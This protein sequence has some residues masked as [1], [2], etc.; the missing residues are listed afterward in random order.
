M[1]LLVDTPTEPAAPVEAPPVHWLRRLWPLP[2]ALAIVAVVALVPDWGR[3]GPA[4]GEAL[5]SV[6]GSARVERADGTV[7]R[8]VGGGTAD[9]PAETTLRQGDGFDLVTGRADLQLN[10]SIRMQARPG[11]SLV[12]GR[13]PE[14]RTGDLLVTGAEP[15]S[16]SSGRTRVR[17][18]GSS[19]RSVAARLAR[20][21]GLSVGLYRGTARIDSAGVAATVHRLRRIEV[22][23]LGELTEAQ[24]V[25]YDTTDP[26]DQRYLVDAI[27]L[28]Q[29]LTRL[30][31]GFMASAGPDVGRAA[32]LA[33]LLDPI[34]RMPSR[35]E[36][37]RLVDPDRPADDVLVGATIS[38]LDRGGSY[39]DR[40]RAVFRFRDAG[41]T[42]GLVAMDRGV[43]PKLVLDA[44]G[45][46][47]EAED[48]DFEDQAGVPG[49]PV[50]D[51]T[52]DG[53][54]D[55]GA[56]AG[57]SDGA[58]GGGGSSGG[59]SD[60]GPVTPTLPPVPTLPPTP[61]VPVTPTLPPVTDPVGG[62]VDGLG[63]TVEDVVD[64]VGDTVDGVLDPEPD[65][66]PNCLL[67]VVCT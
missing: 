44:L 67:G 58:Q 48:L 1:S 20:T 15:T 41:A 42:W 38:G 52:E 11:T 8:R 50:I 7:E 34:A 30:L 21:A 37:A 53:T 60:G 65:G 18:D 43:G 5:V 2:A 24:P 46:V 16:V 17:L 29:Q 39:A 51:E 6:D 27:S 49:D 12:M 47:F 45:Q 26:W 59:G 13:T 14:L 64:G 35:R 32:N 57:G 28:D 19:S 55:S 40:W 25:R 3:A 10:G 54:G 56:G 63:N 33:A 66:G 62:I 22:P 23:A 36:L 4:P 61:T 31:P 9:G